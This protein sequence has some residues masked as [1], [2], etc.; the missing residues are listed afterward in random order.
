MFR[1][2]SPH[3]LTTSISSCICSSSNF[4]SRHIP[5]N[6][7]HSPSL[8]YYSYDK[9]A[10][11]PHANML[12]L[13]D[14]VRRKG[15]KDLK[16]DCISGSAS[17]KECVERMKHLNRSC[18]AIVNEIEGEEE[19]HRRQ[20]RGNLVGFVTEDY[21]FH[22]LRQLPYSY[23]QNTPILSLCP[24]LP[25]LQF[26]SQLSLTEGIIRMVNSHMWHAVIEMEPSS[27]LWASNSEKPFSIRGGEREG[28]G[29]LAL[30]SLGDFAIEIMRLQNR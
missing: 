15:S 21:L 7:T 18:L 19:G 26:S 3:L 2:S 6:P 12:R 29:G 10:L 14:L 1:F 17:V 8:R 24:S 20:E 9:Y 27:L 28:T 4:F 13:G 22:H 16:I 30:Q 23:M 5:I 25:W 11:H